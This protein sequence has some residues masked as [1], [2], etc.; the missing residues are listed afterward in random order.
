MQDSQGQILALT[1]SLQS[2]KR[3]KLFPLRSEA[4]L[5]AL[6]RT[7]RKRTRNE[8]APSPQSGPTS[9]WTS[10]LYTPSPTLSE[11]VYLAD[12]SCY[13]STTDVQILLM[14]LYEANFRVYEGPISSRLLLSPQ[15]ARGIKEKLFVNKFQV[16]D[17]SGY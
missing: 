3:V 1:S 15:Q 12:L 5:K 9:Q 7:P 16:I 13:E 2:L 4:G 11:F 10:F 8:S 14:R 6:R 17:V